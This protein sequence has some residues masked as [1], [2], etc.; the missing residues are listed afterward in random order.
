MRTRLL[1][2]ATLATASL[3]GCGD[4][5]PSDDERAVCSSVQTMLDHLTAGENAEAIL[6]IANLRTV[7]GATDNEELKSKATL[8]IETTGEQ[9]SDADVTVEQAMAEGREA[10]V[11][12]AEGLGGLVDEC[13]RLELAID[14]P[15]YDADGNRLSPEP[16]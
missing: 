1:L 13:N 16:G 15:R 6:E 14:V 7:A 3:A 11:E 5:G 10:L 2:A 12:G 9:V 8:F 4:D